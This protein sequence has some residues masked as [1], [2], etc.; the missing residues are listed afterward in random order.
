[1][2]ITATNHSNVI[3]ADNSNSGVVVKLCDIMAKQAE[4][5]AL[6]TERLLELTR[7]NSQLQS[8]IE[9]LRDNETKLQICVCNFP[10]ADAK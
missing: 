6:L 5:N 3:V 8:E 4:Q 2:I 1:M 7:K 9:L 10:I